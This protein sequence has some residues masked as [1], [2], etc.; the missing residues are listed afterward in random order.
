MPTFS[1]EE[2]RREYI[3]AAKAAMVRP[4]TIEQYIEI[5]EKF[6]IEMFESFGTVCCARY[7]PSTLDKMEYTEFADCN[8][9]LHFYLTCV[10]CPVEYY[11]RQ[12][13][14]PTLLRRICD[15]VH[16]DTMEEKIDSQYF[17]DKIITAIRDGGIQFMR[18]GG[19]KEWKDF[20][21]DYLN[22]NL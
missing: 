12:V 22:R 4:S 18:D 17:N 16:V 5:V 15:M 10:I 13:I 6:T 9:C 20:A 19:F 2:E 8:F 11:S 3:L 1:T 21:L 7:D 14:E